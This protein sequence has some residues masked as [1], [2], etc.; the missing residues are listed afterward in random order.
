MSPAE[1][2]HYLVAAAVGTER[3]NSLSYGAPS[4]LERSEAALTATDAAAKL[5]L[6]AGEAEGAKYGQAII[7]MQINLYSSPDL[8]TWKFEG[9]I[10]TGDQIKGTPFPAP[11][12]MERPK[13]RG[14][15]ACLR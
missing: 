7:S 4:G 6:G 2:C 9:A 14:W 10:L 11:F 12:R 5:W 13:A 8:A 1:S 3:S 15:P